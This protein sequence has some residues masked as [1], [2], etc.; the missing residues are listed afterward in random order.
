MSGF[1]ER[2]PGK[3]GNQFGQLACAELTQKPR[4][5]FF[6]RA[7]AERAIAGIGFGRGSQ[8]IREEQGEAGRDSEDQEPDPDRGASPGID[9]GT[10]RGHRREIVPGPDG[11]VEAFDEK[12][13]QGPGLAYAGCVAVDRE[14]FLKRLG[15]VRAARRMG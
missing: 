11:V 6:D 5:V 13:E 14:R 1:S 7:V 12:S 4:T 10:P 2:H 9:F 15:P 3:F 8:P